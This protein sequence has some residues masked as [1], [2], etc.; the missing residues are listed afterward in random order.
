M[1]GQ[2]WATGG[3]AFNLPENVGMPIAEDEETTYFLFEIH[4]DNP[5]LM[6]GLYDSSGLRLLYTRKV[7]YR[8][9]FWSKDR[10]ETQIMKIPFVSFIWLMDIQG[11]EAIFI[12][13]I[14]GAIRRFQCNYSRLKSASDSD[15]TQSD[16]S[17]SD[18]DSGHSGH[19]GHP[20]IYSGGGHGRCPYAKH[21]GENDDSY[22]DLQ[23]S[24]QQIDSNANKP[25]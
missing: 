17:D 16:D 11:M 20:P 5:E 13:Q 19:S 12:W 25:K 3:D 4:Y 1:C 15:G 23:D 24:P 6:G 7:Q 9:C 22:D 18:D 2:V 21:Y 10:F 14:M 8:L